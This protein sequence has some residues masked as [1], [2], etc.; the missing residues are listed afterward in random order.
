RRKAALSFLTTV[1][2]DPR[3]YGRVVR[4]EGD[5]VTEIREQADLRG[6]RDLASIQEINAGLYCVEMDGLFDALKATSRRNAQ[7]EFYLPDLVPVLRARGRRVQALRH[8]NSV[9]V[10][11]INTRADLAAVLSAYYR[12]RAEE[13]MASGVTIVDPASAWVD[14]EVRVGRDT[15]IHPSVRL[16]GRTR[17]GP[18]CILRTGVR[19]AGSTL[20]EGVEILDHCLVTEATIGK[21]ARVGPFAHLRP[22]TR[23]GPGVRIGNFVETKKASLGRGSKANHLAYLG[24]ATIGR[25]VNVGAGTITCNYDGWDKHQTV[26]RDGVFIGSDTQLVAP[27]TVGR[28]A[29]VGAGSTITR[30]VPPDALAISRARQQAVKGW[31]ARKRREMAVR[32]GRRSGKR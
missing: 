20:A 4:G 11:G 32:R 12:R 23:L 18:G 7:R 26:L 29:F 5:E 1:L 24:D 6:R 13:L 25:D 9:E 2:D 3:G 21:G 30:N 16:E 8:L 15:I 14:A 22:G 10:L 17:I 28:G 27:V 31:A 19:V